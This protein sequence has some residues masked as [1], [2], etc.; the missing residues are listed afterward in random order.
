M[1]CRSP[2]A[3]ARSRV[4]P[5]AR[6]RSREAADAAAPADYPAIRARAGRRGRRVA[7]A[8]HARRSRPPGRA[9]PRPRSELKH[10][11][12]GRGASERQL[13]AAR[14]RGSYC[15]PKRRTSA[16]MP[17][18]DVHRRTGPVTPAVTSRLTDLRPEHAPSSAASRTPPHHPPASASASAH[19]RQPSAGPR[20]GAGAT[21]TT[22]TTAPTPAAGEA[23]SKRKADARRGS[24]SMSASVPTRSGN[25]RSRSCST[26]QGRCRGPH[27]GRRPS[28]SRRAPSASRGSSG[29]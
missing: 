3:Q 19:A 4:R 16:G 25:Y 27:R 22:S 17:Q 12:L 2:R 28:G 7:Q 15:P 10:G 1:A 5:C 26:W 24:T 23:S 20:R 18:R 14:S 11:A 6:R 29:R 8:N 9:G 13:R 21:S